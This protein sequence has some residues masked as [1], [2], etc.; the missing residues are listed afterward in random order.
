MASAHYNLFRFL[1]DEG[2]TA[3]LFTH[4][5]R[6]VPP[7]DDPDIVRVLPI[8]AVAAATRQ[9]IALWFRLSEPGT[10][11]YQVN[12]VLEWTSAAPGLRSAVRAFAPD[13]IVVPDRGL[14]LLWLEVPAGCRVIQVEHHNPARFLSPLVIAATP[15][16]SDVSV[17][18]RLGQRAL[19]K[20][21]IVV[22]PSRYMVDELE[23]TFQFS[24]RVEVIPH[25]LDPAAFVG[26]RARSAAVE[27]G[28]PATTPVMYLPAGGSSVK[29]ERYV[30]PLIE[31]LLAVHP[32]VAFFLSG[33]LSGVLRAELEAAGVGNRV[34]APGPLAWQD[35]LALVAGCRVGLAPSLAENL[36]MAILEALQLGVPVAAFDVGGNRDLIDETCGALVPFLDLPRLASAALELLEQ[37]PADGARERAR[38]IHDTARS[39]WLELLR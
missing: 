15:S 28:L 26:V 27:L 11:A 18:V 35:N 4:E 31:S 32:E 16:R 38:V 17:A 7:D 29:G 21:Q 36:S 8:R 10:S 19:A 23:R 2:F 12:D 37:P 25:V 6:R 30:L 22:C 39:R 5:D 24:G 14:P 33:T 13:V 1:R 20:A 3:K 9:A 34:Y